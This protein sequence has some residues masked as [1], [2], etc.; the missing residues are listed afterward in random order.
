[1]L[2]RDQGRHKC[3]FVLSPPWEDDNIS[4]CSKC[5]ER[6]V[7]IIVSIILHKHE[8]RAIGRQ[9]SGEELSLPPFG[10]GITMAIFQLVGGDCLYHVSLRKSSRTGLLMADKCVRNA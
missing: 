6:Q 10:I 9:D 8:V 5:H 7:L 4:L 1:M 3:H 2:F